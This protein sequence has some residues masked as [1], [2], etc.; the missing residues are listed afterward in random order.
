VFIGLFDVANLIA[1]MS[2]SLRAAGYDVRSMAITEARSR[3][4]REDAYDDT[5]RYWSGG[6]GARLRYRARLIRVFIG[7]LWRVDVFVY[8]WYHSFLPMQLDFVVLRLLRK[9]VVVFYVGDDI[10]YRPIQSKLDEV[11]ADPK[12]AVLADPEALRR[13]LE[14]GR[15]FHK[16]FW[17]T[18]IA[19]KT[20]CRIV[21]TRDT[22]TFQGVDYARFRLAQPR[23]A[24]AAR[25]PATV[26]LIV[27]APSSPLIKGTR[28]VEEAV[29]LLRNEGLPF[30]FELLAGTPN[31]E[32]LRRLAEAD[33]AID[34]PGVWIARFAAEALAAGC[35]VVGGNQPDY[36][37]EG[38]PSPVIQ[39]SPDASALADTLRELIAD[40]PKRAALMERSYS[41]WLENY[42]EERFGEHFENIIHGCAP[43]LQPLP[44]QRRAALRHAER[45]SQ[46]A[47]I[48][49]LW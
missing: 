2:H 38:A 49:M 4:Y 30:R 20:R 5:I 33:V 40:E 10:R 11:L 18:K 7:L 27:H 13:Y 36:G 32:V 29:A 44:D 9:Q 45:A 26:P 12:P 41:Y 15:P 37:G 43:A 46:R 8:V 31:D 23:L 42:S 1:T 35:V 14:G 47:A 19:E 48:R 3:V 24:A 21:S 6:W 39:F 16:A 17:S 34:Q 22:A 25:R 28:Y